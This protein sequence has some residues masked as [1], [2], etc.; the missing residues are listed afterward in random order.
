MIDTSISPFTYAEINEVDSQL[1]V[2]IGL[3]ILGFLTIFVLE[4]VAVK[5]E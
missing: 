4:K 1:L 5:N 3:M 2:A